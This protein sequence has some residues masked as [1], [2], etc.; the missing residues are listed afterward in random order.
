MYTDGTF[1]YIH[2][3]TENF[4]DSFTYTADDGDGPSPPATV[5]ITITPV[6]DA[7]VAVDDSGTAFTTDDDTDF[8]TGNVLTND[9]DAEL[10]I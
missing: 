7:P 6:N 1:E 10:M 4:T 5:N 3:G 8:P 2:D 9:T